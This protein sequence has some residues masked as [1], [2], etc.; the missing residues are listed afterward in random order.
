MWENTRAT[1][2]IPLH[3]QIQW[4]WLCLALFIWHVQRHCFVSDLVVV[5][6]ALSSTGSA[7]VWWKH[8]KQTKKTINK[9]HRISSTL[10]L[11]VNSTTAVVKRN[12]NRFYSEANNSLS[13]WMQT[14]QTLLHSIVVCGDCTYQKYYRNMSSHTKTNDTLRGSVWVTLCASVHCLSI[15]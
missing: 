15:W 13:C 7:D 3:R 5:Q 8:Y 2:V 1:K 12:W 4:K 11:Q 6:A 10:R 14:F 9:S